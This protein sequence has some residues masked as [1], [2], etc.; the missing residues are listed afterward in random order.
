MRRTCGI[1]CR[2]AIAWHDWRGEV[3]ARRGK[4]GD[5]REQRHGPART[6]G[7]RVFVFP[8]FERPATT[9]GGDDAIFAAVAHVRLSHRRCCLSLSLLPLSSVQLSGSGKFTPW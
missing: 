2:R 9:I 6:T 1:T 3:S 5:G 8:A 4:A 7:W